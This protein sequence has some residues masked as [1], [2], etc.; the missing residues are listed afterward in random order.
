MKTY[1]RRVVLA[2]FLILLVTG[3]CCA[4]FWGL[5][6]KDQETLLGEAKHTAEQRAMQLNA[7]ASDKMDTFLRGLDLALLHLRDIYVEDRPAFDKAAQLVLRSYPAEVI[8]SIVVFD[9]AGDLVYASSGIKEK[10]NVRD[11]DHFRIHA[12]GKADQLYIGKPIRGRLTGEWGI[13][14][15]RGI[16]RNGRFVGTI[17]TPLRADYL[18]QSLASLTLR[19]GDRI[20]LALPDG[21]YLTRSKDWDKFL[22]RTLAADRPQRKAQAGDRGIF[23]IHSAT[24]DV[25]RIWAWHRLVNWPLVVSSG[26]DE[27][28]ELAVIREQINLT[29][30]R[31]LYGIVLVMMSSVAIA[32]L[33]LRL[34]REKAR[35]ASGRERYL[36][37]LNTVSDGIHILD[38]KGDLVEANEAFYRMLRLDPTTTRV[39]NVRDWDINLAKAV[40]PLTAM[41]SFQALFE[42]E[43]PY[44]VERPM[45]CADGRILD[46]E[47]VVQGIH[48]DDKHYLLA[49]LRDLTVRKQLEISLREREDLLAHLYDVLPVGI[50]ITDPLGNIVDCNRAAEE[51]LGVTKAEHLARNY[52]GDEWHIV[53]P[54]GSPMPA[55]EYAS[56]RALTGNQP[57]RDVEMGIATPKGERWLMT[58]ALPLKNPRY[59]VVVAYVDITEQVHAR[60]ALEQ[61]IGLR[62]AL[63]D[64]SAVGI[65]LASA[66]RKIE[67]A[68]RR[69]CEMFG[70]EMDEL[71]GQS[72]FK[73]HVDKARFDA[74]GD[75]YAKLFNHA[76]VNIEYPFRR[77]DGSLFWCAVSG[78]PLDRND[79]SKGIIWTLLD[80]TERRQLAQEVERQRGDLETILNNLPALVGYW[81]RTLHSR[82]GNRAYEEWYGLAPGSLPGMHIRGLLGDAVYELNRPM[83]EAA[84]AGQGQEFERTIP[85]RRPGLPTRHVLAH[86]IPDIK[87]GETLG[88]YALVFDITPIKE[89]EFALQRAKETA[90]AA[91]R[92]KSE[93]LA[94][95]SHEIR[96][97]MNAV[98]G[99]ARL[100]EDLATD[101]DLKSYLQKIRQASAALMEILNDILDYSKIEAG[102]MEMERHSFTLGPLLERIGGMFSAQIDNKGLRFHQEV[103]A[104][105]PDL[106]E[107][108]P[109]RLSQVLTNLIGNAVKFTDQGTISL[110]VELVD[111]EARRCSLRFS[112]S[113]SGIGI[114]PEQQ[115][116]LFQAFTQADASITR[117]YGGTGL[118]LAIC[119]SLVELMGGEIAVASQ[120]GQG[121]TFH[122]TAVFGSAD[123]AAPA[124]TDT[125]SDRNLAGRHVL[126]VEDN[127]LN[128]QVAST[129]LEIAGFNVTVADNGNEALRLAQISRY[130]AILMDLHMPGMDGF[131]TARRIRQLPDGDMPIIA[132]TAAAT[133]QDKQDAL[134]AGMNDFIAKPFTPERLIDTL[135]HCLMQPSL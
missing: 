60:R 13:Q 42:R 41:A 74:F 46:V 55:E 125:G 90:E 120:P 14:I 127:L 63:L 2:P 38:R 110:R 132:L 48:L 115:A 9:A 21:A 121:S 128:Q 89:A 78:T 5:L 104:D 96:T 72:F 101:A 29:R 129:F 105:V 15:S 49:S 54:D 62:Q 22:G 116:Q 34:G 114:S 118:G 53:R 87:D 86:Y 75:H 92:A 66:H 119:R 126:L 19:P 88:F 35:I 1:L 40:G 67:Q 95:M 83:I 16:Y 28:A 124:A 23:R 99:F 64:N 4:T 37:L 27:D 56:V 61:G 10:F 77:K 57:V 44:V 76:L 45:R 20:H 134:T 24:D 79:L 122:F 17:A 68:S 26:L 32:L 108:D 71:I 12:D 130:D 6:L 103:A 18:G 3:L 39:L 102:R 80:I 30:Q 100:A 70:Y 98:T 51:I 11:R 109:A 50:A 131:E 117:R 107:G 59:G 43:A 91:T 36:A 106:L 135:R 85:G 81:D 31:A 25:P 113:D 93:F 7:A 52:A 8:R 69:A 73:I 111:R 82:F 133:V 47:V 94:N 33:V 58:S 123:S 84:L 112:V 97:P 65:F